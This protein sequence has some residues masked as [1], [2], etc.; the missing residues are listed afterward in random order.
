MM[1]VSGLF[2]HFHLQILT[3]YFRDCT[4]G[5]GQVYIIHR[6]SSATREL[7]YLQNI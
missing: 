3:S 7:E 2:A 1:E 6:K 4:G 5:G